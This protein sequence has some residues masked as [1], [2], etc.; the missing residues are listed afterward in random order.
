[1]QPE[2]VEVNSQAE[3][4]GS[5]TPGGDLIYHVNMMCVYRYSMVINLQFLQNYV[6]SIF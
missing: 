2:M 3:A 6:C 1:M 4:A 5:D